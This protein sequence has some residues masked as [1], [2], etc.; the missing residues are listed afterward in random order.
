MVDREGRLCFAPNL[1]QGQGVDWTS[2]DRRSA[3]RSDGR[4]RERRQLRRAGRAPPRCGPGLPPRRDGHARDRASAA[5]IVVD[6]R[7]QVGCAR[8]RR[9][10]RPHGGRPGRPARARAGGAAAGSA[11]PRAAGWA[12]WPV[13]R[14]WPGGLPRWS[15]AGRRRSRERAR[16]G[17]LRGRGRAGDADG[18]AGD[19]RG[20]VVG[21]ASAWPT[22]PA[23]STPSASSSAAAWCGAGDLLVESARGRL[24]RAGRGR[25]PAT[26]GGASCRPRFGERAGAVGAALGGAPGRACGDP[27]RRRRCRRS[28]TRPTRRSRRRA[29]AVAAGVDGVFCYDHLW[30]IGQPERPALA[31]FPILARWPPMLGPTDGPAGDRSSGRWW[32]GS[33]LVP[34]AVLVAQFLALEPHWRP[35]RVIAGLGTGDRLSEA[36][37]LA[38]GIPFAPAAERRADMVDAGARAGRARAS[39]SGWR[40]DRRRGSKRRGRPGRPSTCG[41]PSPTLVAAAGRRGP[42]AVEVTWAGP[43]PSAAIRRWPRRLAALAGAGATW[44]DLRLAGRRRRAGR[45]PRHAASAA[46]HGPGRAEPGS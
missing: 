37:N 43:P 3:A 38:Y 32:P 41:T 26:A 40:A 15:R 36:E 14:R 5:G 11:T 35:G 46:A 39:P 34:N 42:T 19:R 8:L 16:R 31:P 30:P 45:R 2:P 7:V 13:R 4:D 24:R 18:A 20:R 10:D 1:P 17:R 23:C 25:R 29:A 44:V 28:A 22:W 9:R 12:C 33:G 27:D 21:R 6:G